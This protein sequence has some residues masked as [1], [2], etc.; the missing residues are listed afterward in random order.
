[1]KITEEFKSQS[2]E[3]RR[4]AVTKLMIRLENDKQKQVEAANQP[5]AG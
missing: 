1:M 4:E 5:K 3:E 2:D